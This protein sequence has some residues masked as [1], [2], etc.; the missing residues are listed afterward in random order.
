MRSSAD[1]ASKRAKEKFTERPEGHFLEAILQTYLNA[2]RNSEHS[3]PYY[4]HFCEYSC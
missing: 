3:I 2:L 4:E 1:V